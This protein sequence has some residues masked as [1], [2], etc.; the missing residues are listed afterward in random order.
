MR[1]DEIKHASQSVSVCIRQHLKLRGLTC[2]YTH[3]SDPWRAVLERIADDYTV[4]KPLDQDRFP[5]S[6]LHIFASGYA[7][8]YYSYKWAEV[9]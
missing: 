3:S 6:F 8:G 4:L 2:C 5:C 1:L 9:S 7:A